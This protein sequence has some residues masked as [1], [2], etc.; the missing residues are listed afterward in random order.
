MIDLDSLI[1]RDEIEQPHNFEHDFSDTLYLNAEQYHGFQILLRQT[2][3]HPILSKEQ[4]QEYFETIQNGA[5]D[6]LK[7]EARNQIIIHN[8]KLVLS[9]AMRYRRR[10]LALEDL[11]QEGNLGLIIAI[12]KFD[13]EK[14]F[15]FSTYATWWV[16]QGIIRAIEYQ[17]NVVRKPSYLYYQKSRILRAREE[18]CRF[19]GREPE[20]DELTEACGISQSKLEKI[21]L[22][23]QAE[24]YLDADLESDGDGVETI[25]SFIADDR[26]ATPAA[27]VS[28]RVFEEQL[29]QLLSAHFDKRK[30]KIINRRLGFDGMEPETLE[31]IGK[32][33]RISHERVR[34]IVKELEEIVGTQEASM[35]AIME[36][37]SKS[38]KAHQRKKKRCQVCRKALKSTQWQYCSDRCRDTIIAKH[39]ITMTNMDRQNHPP[40]H[41][42]SDRLMKTDLL[43]PTTQ[44]TQTS[45]QRQLTLFP[46]PETE[47]KPSN[48]RLNRKSTNNKKKDEFGVQ[49]MLLPI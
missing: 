21:L 26:M 5:G 42:K 10:G 40:I 14:G 45:K 2:M 27:I 44:Y 47:I 20:M 4:E 30:L 31:K 46:L 25:G 23:L 24:T 49:L 36:K 11:I 32:R 13:T 8:Q 37:L 9:I 18:L 41:S 39:Q 7:I 6:D 22:S 1:A 3:Q 38:K 17:A 43:T 15:K 16:R 48:K 33:F 35:S 12:D 29:H 34:Q 28:D 19:L